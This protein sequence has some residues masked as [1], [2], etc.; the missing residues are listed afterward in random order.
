M[1][2]PFAPI[3]SSPYKPGNSVGMPVSSLNAYC[4]SPSVKVRCTQKSDLRPFKNGNGKLFS[5][6][7]VDS[8]GDIKATAFNE[9]ADRLYP[10]LEDGKIYQVSR[11]RVKAADQRYNKTSH[12]YEIAFTKDTEASLLDDDKMDIPTAKFNFLANISKLQDHK[13]RDFV[14]IV[15]ALLDYTEVSTI[16]TKQSN[17]ELVKRELILVDDSNFKVSLT[18]WND[19]ATLFTPDSSGITILLLKNVR[20]TEYNGRSLSTAGNTITMIND[21][22]NPRALKLK[23]WFIQGGKD[24]EFHDF[25]NQ[26]NDLDRPTKK[27]KRED[28]M[29][30]SSALKM[31]IESEKV[32]SANLGL[33]V[34]IFWYYLG[35]FC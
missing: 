18:L 28:F 25:G 24:E 30:I 13:D 35:C 3:H 29:W 19:K 14:D 15:A 7:L 11:F 10:V 17:Q 12:A 1:Q 5:C 16:T 6:V 31:P 34:Y 21:F 20:V 32:F 8:D 33:L 23:E 9:D 26:V 2:S 27:Q 22:S 4:A